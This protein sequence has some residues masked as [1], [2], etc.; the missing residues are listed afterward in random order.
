MGTSLSERF[1]LERIQSILRIEIPAYILFSL[2]VFTGAGFILLKIAVL[3]FAPY[4]LYVLYRVKKYG[5]IAFF[6]AFVLLPYI[7]S[8]LIPMG[9]LLSV[10]FN[11]FPLLIFLIYTFLLKMAIPEWIGEINAKLSR[12]YKISVTQ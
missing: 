3:I 8:R 11:A 1:H 2:S 7:L 9:S 12:R 4:L 5:W 6:F 10:I